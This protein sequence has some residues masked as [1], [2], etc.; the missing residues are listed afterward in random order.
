MPRQLGMGM[1]QPESH[2]EEPRGFQSPAHQYECAEDTETKESDSAEM[3]YPGSLPTR[4]SPVSA[5]MEAD[6]EISDNELDCETRRLRRNSETKRASKRMK[7]SDNPVE[8]IIALQTFAGSWGWSDEL[9][10]L[11]GVKQHDAACVKLPASIADQD[12]FLATLCTIVYLKT[13]QAGQKE[14]WELVVE[15]AESWISNQ[16]Q[17]E[18]P[19][20]ER[21]VEGLF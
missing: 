12:H 8:E 7:V 20:L 3:V 4:W 15:K 17:V 18:I 16:T 13:K 5:C 10:R 6:E 14:V 2:L 1:Q 9:E 11:V 21:M 19:E